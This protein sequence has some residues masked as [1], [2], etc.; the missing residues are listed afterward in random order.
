MIT[1]SELK[2][3]LRYDSNSGKFYSLV[4][5][6]P[7][8]VGSEAGS[9]NSE[10]YIILGIYGY[11]SAAHR[12]A[13]LYMTGSMPADQIDHIN[14]DRSDNKFSNLRECST[15]E[16]QH[17]RKLGP[18]NRSGFKGVCWK[19]KIEKWAASATHNGKPIHI[20]YFTDPKEAAAEYDKV[21][22]ELFGEFALTNKMMGL[23]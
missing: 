1:Q 15:S 5:R 3:L 9:L 12:L 20:G 4:Q 19:K 11:S 14:G 18:K 22:L 17:N 13:W 8:I 21:S 2:K 10:G 7:L 16:N 6:G 23:I